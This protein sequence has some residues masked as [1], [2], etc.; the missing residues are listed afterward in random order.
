MGAKSVEQPRCDTLAPGSGIDAKVEQFG[1]VGRGLTPGA[2]A[3]WFAVIERDQRFEARIV[4]NRPLGGFRAR[5]LEAR[6]G[7]VV[8]F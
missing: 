5:L 7:G 1:F 3:R 6:D 4:P 8:A 2:E